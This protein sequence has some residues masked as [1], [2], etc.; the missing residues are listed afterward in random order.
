MNVQSDEVSYFFSVEGRNKVTNYP[1]RFQGVIT[2]LPLN[3]DNFSDFKKI[4][5]N[6]WYVTDVEFL[7]LNRL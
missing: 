6:D 7:A 5:E 4:I 1:R 2:Y 3:Q